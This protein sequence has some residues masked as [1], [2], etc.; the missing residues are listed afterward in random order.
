V[1]KRQ[2]LGLVTM[3]G[4]IL[5][6]TGPPIPPLIILWRIAEKKLLLQSR[7]RKIFHAPAYGWLVALL[8]F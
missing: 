6:D 4:A 1:Y 5:P 7:V 2:D 3:E 8:A